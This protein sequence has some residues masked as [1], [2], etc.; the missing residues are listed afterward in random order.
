MNENQIEDQEEIRNI[1]IIEDIG[2]IVNLL[3]VSQKD[4]IVV[5]E[6]FKILYLLL[7]KI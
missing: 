1:E 2:K 7:Q 4:I 5:V 6:G 3:Q